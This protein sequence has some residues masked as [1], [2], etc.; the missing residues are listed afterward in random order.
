[1]KVPYFIGFFLT[2]I[3][4]IQCSSDDATP[5]DPGDKNEEEVQELN[6]RLSKIDLNHSADQPYYIDDFEYIYDDSG[7]II[8]IRQWG[9]LFEVTYPNESLIQLKQIEDNVSNADLTAL[10]EIH[11]KDNTVDYITQLTITKFNNGQTVSQSDSIK[12]SYTE[13]RLI[14]VETFTNDTNTKTVDL[15]Y[16]NGNIKETITTL[17]DRIITARY[18]YDTKPKITL[19]D[20]KFESPIFNISSLHYILTHDKLG[21]QSKNNLT[22]T[23]I[24][25]NY[26]LF[27]PGYEEINYKHVIDEKT[28]LLSVIEHS[29]RAKSDEEEAYPNYYPS[30]T[31]DD[32]KVSFEYETY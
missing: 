19:S 29:G 7:K 23:R 18:E 24:S 16:E 8:N 27:A 30:R 25:Y 22:S 2:A 20:A 31:F 14:K 10:H 12:Y 28:G 32:I 17:N 1:M 11:L 13:N 4:C 9:R 21:V 5:S 15:S 3:L 6:Y 26:S